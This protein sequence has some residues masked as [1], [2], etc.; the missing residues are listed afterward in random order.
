MPLKLSAFFEMLQLVVARMLFQ[1]CILLMSMR[2]KE[3]KSMRGMLVCPT[4]CHSVELV[5]LELCMSPIQTLRTVLDRVMRGSLLRWLVKR[6]F[7][8]WLTMLILTRMPC[9]TIQMWDFMPF[10]LRS[11]KVSTPTF[12]TTRYAFIPPAYSISN[13]FCTFWLIRFVSHDCPFW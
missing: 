3:V 7:T 11:L 13:R 12:C 2:M 9:T 6:R 8:P 5:L 4:I 10:F 1:P